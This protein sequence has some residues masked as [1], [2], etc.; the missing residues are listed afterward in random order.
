MTEVLAMVVTTLQHT[1]V[2]NQ[3]VVYLK[4][5]CCSMSI[6]FQF[7]TKKEEEEVWTVYDKHL[8]LKGERERNE[9]RV[10]LFGHLE[11]PQT[12]RIYFLHERKNLGIKKTWFESSSWFKPL[13]T[14]PTSSMPRE[15]NDLFP[16][17]L[18]TGFI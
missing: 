5:T 4:F 10:K 7:K 13:F 18:K 14:Y 16:S 6:T 12:L 3:Q 2:L 1:N 17:A 15:S 11:E 9:S 8:L